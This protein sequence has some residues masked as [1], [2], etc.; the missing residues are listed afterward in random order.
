M[1]T[2]VYIF[3]YRKPEEGITRAPEW[4]AKIILLVA[5]LTG[6][7]WDYEKY[8]PFSKALE[9]ARLGMVRLFI[10]GLI[11]RK[12]FEKETGE[13][14]CEGCLLYFRREDAD[15]GRLIYAADLGW[16][17]LKVVADGTSVIIH[18]SDD[19]NS[20]TLCLTH[21]EWM[22]MLERL[23]EHADIIDLCKGELE[24]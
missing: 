14:G 16:G 17:S 18:T 24:R 19:I 4:L 12:E 20:N 9:E 5:R 8:P 1:K 23:G 21:G 3:N 7:T 6:A 22:A 11:T 2:M 10:R 15:D 13:C